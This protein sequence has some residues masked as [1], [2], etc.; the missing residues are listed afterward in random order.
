MHLS[1][2]VDGS[3]DKPTLPLPPLFAPNISRRKGCYCLLHD[4]ARYV[5][6]TCG[7]QHRQSPIIMRKMST[8]LFFHCTSLE[9]QGPIIPYPICGHQLRI[10]PDLT[11]RPPHPRRTYFGC[12]SIVAAIPR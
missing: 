8:L 12:P 7:K 3:V 9:T 10:L 6:F 5:V 11:P 1:N 4:S 2:A